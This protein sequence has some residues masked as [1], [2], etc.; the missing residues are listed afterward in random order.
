MATEATGGDAPRCTLHA[1][2]ANA[3]VM[4][5][6]QDLLAWLSPTHRQRAPSPDDLFARGV[7]VVGHADG[8]SDHGVSTGSQARRLAAHAGCSSSRP[9]LPPRKYAAPQL[10]TPVNTNT[11]RTMARRQGGDERGARR[12]QRLRGACAFRDGLRRARA[13]HGSDRARR[14]RT[15]QRN[16]TPG[17]QRRRHRVRKRPT[18]KRP[19]RGTPT[20]DNNTRVLNGNE[21]TTRTKR[22]WLGM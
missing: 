14:R 17:G 7:A 4:L 22:T 2:T 20:A 13:R 9:L 21:A 5:E 3:L 18:I 6:Q 11:E 16:A 15:H 19:Q 10:A 8:R 1:P 12:S